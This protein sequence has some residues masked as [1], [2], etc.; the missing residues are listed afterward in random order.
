MFSAIYADYFK[1]STEKKNEDF[2]VG[3]DS[4]DNTSSY[5]VSRFLFRQL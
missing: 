2:A 5:D 3:S 1:Y 4:S